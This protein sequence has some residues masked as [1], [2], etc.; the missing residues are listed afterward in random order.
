[1]VFK[2]SSGKCHSV[3][4]FSKRPDTTLWTQNNFYLHVTS[5]ILSLC[6][7]FL[8]VGKNFRLLMQSWRFF[9]RPY[10]ENVKFLKNCSYDFYKIWHS[11]STPKSAPVCTMA[12][13]SYGWDVRNIA[14]IN[15]KMSK[16]PPIL[17]FFRFSQTL[18]DLKE[19]LWSLSTWYKGL[20]CAISS[21]SYDCDSSKSKRKSPSPTPFYRTCGSGVNYY[22][23]TSQFWQC[24]SL[25]QFL[26]LISTMIEPLQA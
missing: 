5:F 25:R 23:C 6:S 8:R 18:Y 9:S 20:I 4:K 22:F 3:E 15:T 2:Q 14:K 7:N 10:N 26:Q 24:T 21:K 19:L 16:K 13:K 12:S 17:N 1:M 11:H